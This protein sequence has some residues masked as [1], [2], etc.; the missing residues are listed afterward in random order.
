MEEELGRGNAPVLSLP[1]LAIYACRNTDNGLT[2]Y[3]TNFR[4]KIRARKFPVYLL[5][6]GYRHRRLV[7]HI[8][9]LCS[10]V[11]PLGFTK[12]DIFR[13]GARSCLYIYKTTSCSALKIPGK[14]C[15]KITGNSGWNST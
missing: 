7:R 6:T 12:G 4:L 13:L 8:N 10:F 9:L 5:G 1:V 2:D 11:C 3:L 15:L 14:F